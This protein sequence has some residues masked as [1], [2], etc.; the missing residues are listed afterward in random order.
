MIEEI[1]K[2]DGMVTSKNKFDI[3]IDTESTTPHWF[4]QTRHKIHIYAKALEKSEK[5]QLL[6][7]D[8]LKKHA[9][10]TEKDEEDP[11][12]EEVSTN[13]LDNMGYQE[14]L[15]LAKEKEFKFDKN[16]KKNVL[17]EVLKEVI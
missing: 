14:L 1:K 5:T 2:F 8:W 4:Y 12:V 16:P 9:V 13:D 6:A 3:S 15:K 10:G 7:L 11:S 17:I